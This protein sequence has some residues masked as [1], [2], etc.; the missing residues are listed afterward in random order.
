MLMR[1]VIGLKFLV[2]LRTV[3]GRGVEVRKNGGDTVE[4]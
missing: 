2:V 4:R 1:V 3:A